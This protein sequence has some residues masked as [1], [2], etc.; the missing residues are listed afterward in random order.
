MDIVH[1]VILGVVEGVT[2]FLPISSTGHMIIAADIMRVP[3]TEFVKT[4]EIAIQLGA[5]AAVFSIYW[6]VFLLDWEI[7]KKVLAAFVPTAI[8]GFILY[9][10]IKKFLLGNVAIVGAALLLG[11][12]AL[13]IFERIYKKNRANIHTLGDITY[14]QAFIIGMAQ[15]LAV[16]PGVSRS[17]ATIIGGLM[18][19]LGRVTVVEFSFL[20]AVPTMLAAT[21]LDII[22]SHAAISAGDWGVLGIGFLTAMVV[23]YLSVKFLLGWVRRNNFI[24]FGVYRIMMGIFVLAFLR[25]H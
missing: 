20:L 21:A 25:H 24:A 5:I 11:G 1:A 2:E 10:F 18:L 12:I 8:V 23:A 15:A 19:G 4:F 3:E 6:R 16:V 9:K 17:A 13:I 7:G 14:I 22:K